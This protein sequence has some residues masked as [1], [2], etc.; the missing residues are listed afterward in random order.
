M[1]SVNDESAAPPPPAASPQGSPAVSDDEEDFFAH[2]DDAIHGAGVVAD[3][4]P[5]VAEHRPSK[6]T[7]VAPRHEHIVQTTIAGYLKKRSPAFPHPWQLRYW[8]VS[9]K[10]QLL[11]YASEADCAAK[12]PIDMVDLQVRAAAAAAGGGGGAAGGGGVVAAAAANPSPS[13]PRPHSTWTRW[14]TS[15][16]ARSS[17]CA[18]TTTAS[19]AS[20]GCERWEPT[21]RPPPQRGSSA[22]TPTSTARAPRRAARWR[23]AT[24][25][26]RCIRSASRWSKRRR[27]PRA[28]RS[29][30][31]SRARWRGSRCSSA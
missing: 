26:K 11:Y 13:L 9:A 10:R 27:C 4:H 20:S 15:R 3:E 25:A 6:A 1:E 2:V 28:P 23:G 31:S 5:D 21:P 17:C 8:Q 12:E 29:W 14:S 22:C 24:T 30:S 19:R 16:A 7:H 18:R